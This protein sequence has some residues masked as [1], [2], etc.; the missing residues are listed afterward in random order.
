MEKKPR[1]DEDHEWSDPY[2]G[3]TIKLMTN[4]AVPSFAR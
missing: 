3:G 1:R 2:F 4:S